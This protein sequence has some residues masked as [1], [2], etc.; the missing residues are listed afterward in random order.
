GATLGQAE[1]PKPN[2]KASELIGL[3]VAV[4]V[5]LIGFGSVAAAGIPL[6]TALVA[7]F[8]GLS[9]LGLL[10]AAF[11]F[12]TVSPTLAAMMGLGVGIDYS[13]FLI[14]RHRQ[15]LMDGQRPV[16]SA[17]D[18]AATAGRSVL[19]AGC[20]VVVAICGLYASGVSFLGKLGVAAAVTV[21]V[22]VIG[23]LT[24][25]PAVFGLV[26]TAIDRWAVR[27]PVAESRP[28]PDHPGR[29][30]GWARYAET[31]ERRAWWFLAGGV[32]VL[33][34]LA[35]PLFSI[36]LGHI[37][38]GADPTSYTDRRAFDLVTE[39]FGPGENGPFTVVVTAPGGASSAS[40]QALS[41]SVSAALTKTP[42]VALVSPTR[43]TP[44]GKLL[45]T[46]VIPTTR[47]QDEA[48]DA[49]ARHL[50]DT[51]LPDAVTSAA[52]TAGPSA[53]SA[54]T[55]LTGS[56]AAQ[57]QFRDLLVE[58]LPY[59]FIAVVLTAFVI[60]L[61][62]FRGLAVAVKAALL[63]LLSIGAA[64]GVVVAVFQW[65]WGGSALGVDQDVPVESYVPMMMFAITFGLSMDYEVFLLSRIRES[66]LSA[67]DNRRAVGEGLAATARVIT[68]AAIIMSSVFF[69][70]VLSSSVVVKMLAVG[71][72]ASILVDATVVRLVL[73]PATMTL[74]GRANWWTPRWLDRILP[75][76]D[77][78]G[79]AMPLPYPTSGPAASTA[80][81]AGE[82]SVG[83]PTSR[84]PDG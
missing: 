27:Q 5:L 22:A 11:T 52:T 8:G 10:T 18:T 31:V 19:V 12:P 68:C 2:D 17:G 37:D 33:G 15:H 41:G 24:L 84:R 62:V 28:D 51:V 72:A 79:S 59:V 4:A 64:Y 43:A 81:G 42:G 57:L 38:N 16:P 6:I 66:W 53:A 70:F 9:V 14:T 76:L 40:G 71:L 44:D 21:V 26:G 73:V 55:Y 1:R 80:S 23:A 75:H 54:H 67:G 20:T 36:N 30:H 74:L 29:E 56:T 34:I 69:A 48:T 50:S 3:G 78:E 61:A 46:S 77:P 47:P 65:G 82:A 60:L 25:L 49:L 45:V 35:I 13:L 83:R 32:V 63:N 39:G 7:L 58:R